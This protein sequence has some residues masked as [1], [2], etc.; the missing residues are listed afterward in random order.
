MTNSRT[1]DGNAS[2]TIEV[3][4]LVFSIDTGRGMKVN[5]LLHRVVKVTEENRSAKNDKHNLP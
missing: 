4:W 5:E 1:K 2:V 3:M